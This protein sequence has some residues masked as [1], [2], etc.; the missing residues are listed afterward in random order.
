MS[1]GLG[2]LIL[3]RTGKPAVTFHSGGTPVVLC[4]YPEAD[5]PGCTMQACRIRDRRAGYEA[6]G[7]VV[8]GVAPDPVTAIKKLA[9]MQ[10]LNF[11]VL[12]ALRGLGAAAA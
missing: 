6:A 10:S 12:E 3:R 5:T 9:D 2:W 7:A 11:R 1:L 8:L 4:F